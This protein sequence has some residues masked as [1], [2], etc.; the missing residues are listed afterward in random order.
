LPAGG[1]GATCR[2][3]ALREAGGGPDWVRVGGRLVRLPARERFPFPGA[4]REGQG[5][6]YAPGAASR[7]RTC[8]LPGSWHGTEAHFTAMATSAVGR[9]SSV[10]LRGSILHLERFA[11]LEQRLERRQYDGPALDRL[12]VGRVRFRSHRAPHGKPAALIIGVEGEEFE[13]LMTR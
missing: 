6:A 3:H 5:Q 2:D 13:D 4:R 7:W 10:G 8:S 12:P 1:G 9:S 11:G